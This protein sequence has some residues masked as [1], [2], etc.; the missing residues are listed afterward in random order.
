VR[1]ARSPEEGAQ[2]ANRTRRA[3]WADTFPYGWDADDRVSRRELLRL[4]V[5]ASGA[6]FAATGI[7]AGLGYARD[8]VKHKELR[9]T[10]TGEVPPGGAYYFDYIDDQKAILLHL[11]DGQFVAFSGK[12]T[13]LSCAVYWDAERGELLCPCHEGVFNPRTGGVIAGP[14]AR[15]LEQIALRQE[16]DVLIAV[17]QSPA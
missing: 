1:P 11:D 15:P 5:L 14:P 10:T 6:L 8:R 16:G 9:I 3:R 4:A 12:C 13:H 2:L 17:A 7:L